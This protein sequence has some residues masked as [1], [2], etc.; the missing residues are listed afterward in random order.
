MEDNGQEMRMINV[1]ACGAV[2]GA[3][4]LSI[5][6]LPVALGLGAAATATTSG[7]VSPAFSGA[8]SYP[9][10]LFSLI[11]LLSYFYS[12]SLFSALRRIESF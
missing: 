6:A 11:S 12:S 7:F 8:L 4:I 5:A 10:I 1:L 2:L 3:A 9:Y